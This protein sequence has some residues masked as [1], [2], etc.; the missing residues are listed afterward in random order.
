MEN[1]VIYTIEGNT[2]SDKI[3]ENEGGCVAYK[4][5][6]I[7]WANGSRRIDGYG[8]PDYSLV[9]PQEKGY[10]QGFLRAADGKRWWYQFENGGYAAEGWYWLTEQTGGTSGWY[11]FD[12]KGYMLTGYQN[13][14]DGRKYFL[15][16]EPG[17]N[18]GKC[19]V[20]D[21]RGVLMVAD[22]DMEN[23]CYKTTDQGGN[24]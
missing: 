20:T 1:G 23:E 9:E 12:E 3:L 18:E 5:Y 8:R 16:P 21:P 17:I 10:T 2:S 13:A 6:P 4:Q 7:G 15:C 22:W 19:M 14:P 24:I 11:L